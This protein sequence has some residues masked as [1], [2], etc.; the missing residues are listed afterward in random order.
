MP[1]LKVRTILPLMSK[2]IDI[3]YFFQR[4]FSP[5]WNDEINQLVTVYQ[6]INKTLVSPLV[7][8]M[9]PTSGTS[10]GAFR[11]SCFRRP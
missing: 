6:I 9:T 10:F 4:S 2:C 8:S 1:L 5:S 11:T 7:R 3:D